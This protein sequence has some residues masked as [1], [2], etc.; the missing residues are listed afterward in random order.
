MCSVSLSS[1]KNGVERKLRELWAGGGGVLDVS[2]VL[3]SLVAM[4]GDN[5]K[6]HP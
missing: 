4:P 2:V 5:L 6:G 1:G 3:V